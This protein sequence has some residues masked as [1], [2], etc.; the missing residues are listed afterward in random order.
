MLGG[1]T[2][3]V[4]DVIGAGSLG[5]M[6][7]GALVYAG[8]EV[9]FWTRTRAQAAR[10][11]ENGITINQ[12]DG[13]V[14]S[15]QAGRFEARELV[16]LPEEWRK[17]PGHII[18][19]MTK[20]GGLQESMEMLTKVSKLDTAI[21]CFQNG[22]G[23]IPV[24]TE[25]FPS[26]RVYAA[27]TTEGAKR[28]DEIEVTRAG[29]GETHIGWS[30]RA[31]APIEA[32][33]DTLVHKLLKAGFDTKSSN[34]IDRLIYRKLVI[35]AV[36]NPLTSLWKIPNGELLASQER[37]EAMKQLYT[38]AVAVYDAHR[39]EYDANLWEQVV[40]VCQSTSSNWSSM[41]MDVLHGRPT[42][43]AAINGSIVAMAR[44]AEMRA[45][46]HQLVWKLIEGMP[47]R[48]E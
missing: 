45:E 41:C 36:I 23:H 30:Y 13:Q 44:E 35:N 21:F 14:W 11:L 17:K 31:G 27:I 16:S 10:L 7:G 3:L 42:E 39:I 33:V 19:L 1:G 34:E 20:Q 40:A 22:T 4:I 2:N 47:L 32:E 15:V 46:G 18:M 37:M 24:I 25:A 6:Y 8:E 29:Y 26:A 12:P 9:R 43:I 38:E 28:I 5:L 48:R